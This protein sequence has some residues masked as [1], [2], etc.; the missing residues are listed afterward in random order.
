MTKVRQRLELGRGIFGHDFFVCFGAHGGL[1]D[2]FLFF[3]FIYIW[4]KQ[5]RYANQL[6]AP[7]IT[8]LGDNPSRAMAGK[9]VCHGGNN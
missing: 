9:V 8:L 1:L 6:A 4:Q 2:F 3:F 7:L 5:R